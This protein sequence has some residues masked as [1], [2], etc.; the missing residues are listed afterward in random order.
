MPGSIFR[1]QLASAAAAQ[2]PADAKEQNL[3]SRKLRQQSGCA[4]LCR[5][6]FCDHVEGMS[7]R[8]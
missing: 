6:A 1:I 8:G 5:L 3:G 7:A 2:Q 4:A